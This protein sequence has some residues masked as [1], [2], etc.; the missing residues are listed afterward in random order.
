[1]IG[2]DDLGNPDSW[3]VGVFNEAFDDL[4]FL[5]EAAQRRLAEEPNPKE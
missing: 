1:M 2:I 3:P 4:V 5:R